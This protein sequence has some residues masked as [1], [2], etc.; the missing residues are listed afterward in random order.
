MHDSIEEMPSSLLTCSTTIEYAQSTCAPLAANTQPDSTPQFKQPPRHTPTAPSSPILVSAEGGGIRAAYWTAVS[1]EELSQAR[2]VPLLVDTA[3]LS[4][5]SG[6]SLGIATF[7][8][9][10]E[11]PREARLPCIREFLSGDFLSPLLA[12]LLFLDV[13]R[14]VLPAWLLDTHRGDY[15]ED[16]M[17]RR[18]LALTKSDYFYRSLERAAGDA[19]GRVAV[20]LNAT[21]ALSGQY[22]GLTA[23]Q[24]DG[25][26]APGQLS[27]SDL[28]MAV[29]DRLPDLRIAQAVHM[30]ARF[31]YLSP[32]PD[33][34]IPATEA[35]LV[36]FGQTAPAKKAVEDPT[37][38]V[39]VASL[40][41]GGYFDNS[42]LWP[43][44]RLLES[45]KDRGADRFVIHIVNDQIRNCRKMP[46]NTGCIDAQS[47]LIKERLSSRDGWLFRPSDAIQAVRSE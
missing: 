19:K 37:T 7:L 6:G 33:L 14:L 5:V 36:L 3:I 4:G 11:L 2:D 8:A 9:A 20:Y 46:S 1:L 27:L 24:T 30:S 25:A 45:D 18:W 40:V 26:K 22:I 47:R 17:A 41:D 21:D 44:L 42:G 34:R 13:P 39:S 15:F 23:R 43:A 35:S 32:N 28:N 29:L 10:Q 12:G 16:F 31:P 38:A